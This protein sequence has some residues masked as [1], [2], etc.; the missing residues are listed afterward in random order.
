MYTEGI[1]T[2]GVKPLIIQGGL[3]VDLCVI[4][5]D[6]VW[7]NDSAAEE[8]PKEFLYGISPLLFSKKKHSYTSPS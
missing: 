1:T 3:L 6:E 5:G 8:L 4:Y 7:M 2:A